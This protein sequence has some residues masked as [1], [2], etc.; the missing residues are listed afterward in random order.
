MVRISWFPHYG[1]LTLRYHSCCTVQCEKRKIR[2]HS[3]NI[4]S[5][6]F[7]IELNKYKE[8]YAE[9]WKVVT[10]ET[11]LQKFRTYIISTIPQTHFSVEKG[12][13]YSLFVFVKPNLY[14]STLYCLVKRC[15]DEIFDWVRVNFRTVRYAM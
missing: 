15:F 10:S 3:Q 13:L 5:N 14:I 8:N 6:H 9:F 12:E 7:T 4:T 11:T 2:S 1:R